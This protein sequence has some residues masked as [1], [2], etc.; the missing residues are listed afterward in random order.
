MR[1]LRLTHFL[2]SAHGSLYYFA[3]GKGHGNTESGNDAKG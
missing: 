3:E 1:R 2:I